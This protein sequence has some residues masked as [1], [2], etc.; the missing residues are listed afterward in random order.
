MRAVT[1]IDYGLGNIL[2]VARAVEKIGCS[3]LI[4][5]N[6][7]EL[8]HNGPIIVPG[9]GAF[10][11]AMKRIDKLGLR[12]DISLAADRGI[13]VLGICLGMQLFFTR[14]EEHEEC[15][16]LN[17]IPGSVIQLP[18][19]SSSGEGLSIPSI[20]WR[21]VTQIEKI[22]EQISMKVREC[23]NTHS[24]YFAHSYHVIPND[25]SHLVASYQRGEK[26]VAAVVNRD[27]VWGVQFHPEKS[28]KV[29]L[30]FLSNFINS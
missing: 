21:Q 22:P 29:G 23:I 3:V 6:D 2:N 16:G 10:P 5:R 19:Q 18:K 11:E 25:S 15:F 4:A 12:H 28:G 14:G 13:P 26:Q 8:T 27:N 9:V 20:G 24:F 7:N 17:L 30:N 1:I